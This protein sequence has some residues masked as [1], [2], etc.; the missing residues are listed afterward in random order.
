VDVMWMFV[1]SSMAIKHIVLA[2]QHN[3]GKRGEL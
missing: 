1:G 3:I 2:L